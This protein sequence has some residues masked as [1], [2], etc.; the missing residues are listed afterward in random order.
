ML[1]Y[2]I[3]PNKTLFSLARLLSTE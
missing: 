2:F 3:S 1:R